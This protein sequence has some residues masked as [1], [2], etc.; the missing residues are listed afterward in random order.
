[1]TTPDTK[2]ENRAQLR[3]L[4]RRQ[5]LDAAKRIFAEH[6]LEAAT[7]REIAAAAGCTT[8]AIYPLF[9]AKEEIYAALLRES[10]ENV[11]GAVL[12]ALAQARQDGE[13]LKAAAHAWFEYYAARPAEVSLGLYLFRSDSRPG[14]TRQGLGRDIDRELNDRLRQSLEGFAACL[15]RLG[16]LSDTL[17][18]IETASLF[19]HLLGLLTAHHTGRLKPLNQEAPPLLD[20]HLDALIARLQWE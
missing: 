7:M 9:P 18:E 20:H 4:K 12:A 17:T 1:M 8:G 3:D 5:I 11:E 10:L 14:L 13:K 6:G 16:Q 2:T 15:R 19:A